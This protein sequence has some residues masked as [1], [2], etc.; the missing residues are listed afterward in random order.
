MDKHSIIKIKWIE[1]TSP[2]QPVSHVAALALET[3]LKLVSY[4]APLAAKH[5]QE[6][7]EYVHQLRV[8]TRRASAALKIFADLLPRGRSWKIQKRLGSVRRAAGDARDLDVLGDRLGRMLQQPGTDGLDKVLRGIH[9][10]RRWAQ[11]PL[12]EIHKELRRW[13]FDEKAGKLIERIRWRQWGPEPA[14]HE[15]ARPALGQAA[16]EFFTAASKDLSDITLLHQMRIA[17]KRLRYTMELLAGAFHP[18]F[19]TSLYPVFLEVQDKLGVVN[20][21][22][23]ARARFLAWADES[24]RGQAETLRNLAA[25]EERQIE[26]MRLQFCGWWTPQRAD[27]LRHRFEDVMTAS[28]EEEPRQANSKAEQRKADAAAAV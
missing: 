21:H 10:R 3:R 7:V 4:H 19:K 11:K 6:D 8:S 27:D 13:C 22:A 18:S 14:F 25:E 26:S 12:V 28:S 16:D 5:F 9:R 20:D 17:G 23:T 1:G 24:R 2:D 15:L